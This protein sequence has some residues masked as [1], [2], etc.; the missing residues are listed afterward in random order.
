MR[1]LLNEINSQPFETALDKIQS[2]ISSSAGNVDFNVDELKFLKQTISGS[3]SLFRGL[4]LMR[5]R[6]N[7]EHQQIVDSLNVGDEV[8]D[9]LIGKNHSSNNISSWSKSLSVAKRYSKEAHVGMILELSPNNES[10]ICDSSNLEKLMKNLNVEHDI[11]DSFDY[12]KREKE[13]FINSNKLSNKPKVLL[14]TGQFK[15]SSGYFV[16]K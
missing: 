6:L 16:P 11:S 15:T 12:L 2:L 5:F 4:Y 3:Y 8:P 14:K 1:N 7:V 9:F 13:V 10:I